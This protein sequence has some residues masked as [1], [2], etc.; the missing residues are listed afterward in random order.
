MLQPIAPEQ[1]LV[2]MFEFEY[3]EVCH[4]DVEDHTAI[5]FMGNW[6]AQ[7]KPDAE[8]HVGNCILTPDEHRDA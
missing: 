4:G 5:P 2:N 6:F 1:W 3:C 8:C 7:C